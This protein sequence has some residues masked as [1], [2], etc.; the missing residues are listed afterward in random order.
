M[1]RPKKRTQLGAKSAV[2]AAAEKAEN[3]TRKPSTNKESGAAAPKL[4]KKDNK[5]KTGRPQKGKDK[6]AKRVSVVLTEA[7]QK[8]LTKAAQEYYPVGMS[9]NSFV[10][11]ILKEAG[12]F[13]KY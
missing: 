5:A 7:E 9:T 12:I 8:S 11:A 10:R 6:L 1:N 3:N 2:E 4:T 13:E